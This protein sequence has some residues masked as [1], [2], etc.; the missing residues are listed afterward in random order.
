MNVLAIMNNDCL[1][2]LFPETGQM[3]KEDPANV[4]HY[5]RGVRNVAVISYAYPVIPV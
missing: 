2:V 4:L 3:T 1:P 5:T